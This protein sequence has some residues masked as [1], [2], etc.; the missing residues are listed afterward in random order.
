MKKWVTSS[1]SGARTSRGRR[2]K[3][4]YTDTTKAYRHIPVLHTVESIFDL[5]PFD[6]IPVA[7]E[8]IDGSMPLPS[9]QIEAALCPQRLGEVEQRVGLRTAERVTI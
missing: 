7:I 3:Q 5:C 2:Y 8:F 6:C 4:Q 9:V 1:R